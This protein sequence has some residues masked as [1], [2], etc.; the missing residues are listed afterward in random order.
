MKFL[1]TC[2]FGSWLLYQFLCGTQVAVQKAN[3][4]LV[5]A[6]EQR[7]NEVLE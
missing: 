7:V 6:A 5:Q 1:A 4:E 2:I 3:A